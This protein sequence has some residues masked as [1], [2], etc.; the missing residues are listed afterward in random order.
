MSSVLHVQTR[1]YP[2]H[3]GNLELLPNNLEVPGHGP[4]GLAPGRLESQTYNPERLVVLDLTALVRSA[5]HVPGATIHHCRARVLRAGTVL[6]TYAMTHETDLRALDTVALDE[7]DAAVNTALRSA[8]AHVINAV[9][10]TAAS[11]GLLGNPT[12]VNTGG[13]STG[14]PSSIDLRVVRYNAHFV[15]ADP[16]WERDHRVLPMPLGPH[17]SILMSY[18][19]AW[20]LDADTPFDDVLTALE[21]ADVTVAQISVLFSAMIGSRR[22]LTQ[23]A[24]ANTGLMEDHDFRRFLDQV[25]AEFYMLD[26]YRLESAQSHRATYIAALANVGLP[27]AQQNATELLA[28]VNSSLRAESTMKTQRL[29]GRLNRVAAMLTVAVA[30]SFTV[31][32]M[33]YVAPDAPVAI[34]VA[35]VTAVVALG[36]ATVV[37]TLVARGTRPSRPD[38]L[39]KERRLFRRR[40]ASSRA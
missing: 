34:R 33:A 22:I 30:G 8:D 29:D 2:L 23:L 15:T 37:A 31:D 16:P 28:H 21:P 39:R 40:V 3:F 26:A 35:V 10:D 4:V 27:Q 6:L 32:I 5:V 1:A 17:C 12:V 19:Y 20:D 9:L 38:R 14:M 24:R 7:F 25:W 36:I 18:T 11:S 13:I